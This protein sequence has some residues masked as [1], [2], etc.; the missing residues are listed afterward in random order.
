MN[1]RYSVCR[2]NHQAHTAGDI[3]SDADLRSAALE[4]HKEEGE[5]S[6]CRAI[7]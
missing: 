6:G 7:G 3:F 1:D 4:R 2:V 5:R